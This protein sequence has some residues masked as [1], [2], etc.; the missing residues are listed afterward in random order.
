MS[1]NT[2]TPG[3]GVLGYDCPSAAFDGA[4]EAMRVNTPAAL[5]EAAARIRA[6]T[7]AGHGKAARLREL[8]GGL[9]CKA[10]R[11]EREAS[12]GATVELAKAA[13]E[14]GLLEAE[15]LEVPLSAERAAELVRAGRVVR[16]TVGE[17][18]SDDP[19]LLVRLTEDGGGV[20]SESIAGWSAGV[21]EL[22]CAVESTFLEHYLRGRSLTLEPVAELVRPEPGEV[23]SRAWLEA[24]RAER[25]EIDARVAAACEA[26]AAANGGRGPVELHA[27]K[28]R[29]LAELC[30][31]ADQAVESGND[32]EHDAL[33][34]LVEAVRELLEQA[35][36]VR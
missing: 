31:Q 16:M 33:V 22:V 11:L 36:E 25:A 21:V 7:C 4:G 12:D 30:E 23:G 34:A 19:V 10:A 18:G 32:E 2:T 14:S 35:G 9:E 29:E 6:T 8:A 24:R 27:V 20:E 13:Q 1:E 15:R 17:E 5:R 28:M 3:D 26:R